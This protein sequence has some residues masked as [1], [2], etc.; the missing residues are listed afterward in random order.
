MNIS[1]KTIVIV[2]F[3]LVGIFAAGNWLLNGRGVEMARVAQQKIDQQVAENFSVELYDVKIADLRESYVKLSQRISVTNAKIKAY[4][5]K[6]AQLE[7]AD[8]SDPEQAAK[9]A[10]KIAAYDKIIASLSTANEKLL[11]I[12]SKTEDALSQYKY[13]REILKNKTMLADSLKDINEHLKDFSLPDGT[14]A[15]DPENIN[16]M[17]DEAIIKQEAELESYDALSEID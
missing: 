1:L 12:K 4:Q 13:Q 8:I 16:N 3:A 17:I 15:I 14:S 6:K 7:K 11:G 9:A 10:M 2:A 5:A